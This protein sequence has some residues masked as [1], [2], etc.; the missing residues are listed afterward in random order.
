M[1]FNVTKD[2]RRLVKIFRCLSPH[3]RNELLAGATHSAMESLFPEKSIYDFMPDTGSMQMEGVEYLYHHGSF[4]YAIYS[5][6]EETGEPTGYLLG[7][8]DWDEEELIPRFIFATK[9]ADEETGTWFDFEADFVREYIDDWRSE[10]V[11]R[12]TEEARR[13]KPHGDD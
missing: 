7:S 13:R 8:S 12:C 1:T 2:E 3:E 9:R 6:M 11:R 4:A 5:G 10:I